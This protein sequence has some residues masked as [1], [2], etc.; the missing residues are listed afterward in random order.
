MV[1]KYRCREKEEGEDEVVCV[2]K[3]L[4]GTKQV[5]L[6]FSCA[7]FITRPTTYHILKTLTPAAYQYTTHSRTP[8]SERKKMPL[9]SARARHPFLTYS[10]LHS[11]HIHTTALP[12]HKQDAT[13]FT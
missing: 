6:V 12:P 13:S 5:L 2:A 10:H 9:R 4:G 11:H 1:Y 3:N 8:G 7:L